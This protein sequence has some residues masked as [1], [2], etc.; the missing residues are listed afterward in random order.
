MCFEGKGYGSRREFNLITNGKK[1]TYNVHN[2]EYEA[3]M[4]IA[5]DV[6]F[7]HMSDGDELQRY[8]QMPA[9]K[10]FKQ[11]GQVD[12]AAMIKEFT[13][14]NEGAVHGKPVVIPTEAKSLTSLEK[15]KS[16]RAVNLIKEKRSGDIKGRTCVNG[17]TQRKYLKKKDEYVASPTA[18]L[19]T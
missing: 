10:G 13:Q 18:S 6:V 4:D 19:L 11:F 8:S 17:S 12:V 2:H 1:E 9:K 15:R 3:Y 7:A 14:L 16:L 5:C